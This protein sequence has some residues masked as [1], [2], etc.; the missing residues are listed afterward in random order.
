MDSRKDS[1]VEQQ[2]GVAREEIAARAYRLWQE[3]GSPEGSPE[4]DWFRAE[5]EILG[6]MAK[7]AVPAP[8]AVAKV[9]PVRGARTQPGPVRGT[10]ESP[11]ARL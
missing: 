2:A 10:P 5:Q 1:M 8:G 11:R 4:A 3:R 9:Q 6:E 7:P